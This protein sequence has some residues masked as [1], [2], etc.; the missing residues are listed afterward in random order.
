ML[1]QDIYDKPFAKKIEVVAD[2]MCNTLVLLFFEKQRA[3]GTQSSAWKAR[4]MRKADIRFNTLAEWAEDK[5]F[6]VG[7]RFSLADVAA[8]TVCR[9][10]D[11]RFSEYPWRTRHLNLARYADKLRERQWF[12]DTLPAG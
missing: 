5:D 2:R 11:I 7:G 9:Y 12:K 4:Q 1:S 6:M 3:G 10:V 8:G